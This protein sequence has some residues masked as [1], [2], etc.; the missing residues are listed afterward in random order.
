[1]LF[2]TAFLLNAWA[3]N[4][5]TITFSGQNEYQTYVRLDSVLVTDV[6][7]NWSEMLIYPDTVIELNNISG[8]NSYPKESVIKLTPNPLRGN[9]RISFQLNEE[10]SAHIQITDLNGRKCASWS[11]KLSVGEHSFNVTLTVPQMYVLTVR[12]PEAIA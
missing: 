8:V 2:V 6:T 7:R 1:M 11:G 9:A 10:A 4:P 5:I 12:T 3:Q